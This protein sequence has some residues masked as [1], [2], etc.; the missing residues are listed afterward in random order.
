M[1][2]KPS[3]LGL[4]NA[5]AVGERRAHDVLSAWRDATA[6]PEL[7][8]VLEVVAIREKEHAA[9]FTKRL[10]ELGYSVRETASREFDRSLALA[11][12]GADDVRKFRQILGYG[13]ADGDREDPLAHVFEDRTIDPE[14]GALLGRFITEERDSERRLRAAW[15]RA[16]TPAANPEPEDRLLTEIAERIE[17]LSRTLEEVKRLR[18]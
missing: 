9:T 10:C 4:L 7:K 17:R 2:Q 15:Q 18:R 8:Q 13:T 3:Y 6:D 5:I 14:T 12:S 1:S 16:R 11:A